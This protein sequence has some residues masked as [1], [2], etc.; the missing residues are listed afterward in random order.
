MFWHKQINI[1]NKTI[2]IRRI[3]C[4]NSKKLFH[5]TNLS[6]CQNVPPAFDLQSQLTLA[7]FPISITMEINR[8]GCVDDMIVPY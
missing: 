6:L 5:F 2:Q 7:N 8:L 1:F 3:F 4:C